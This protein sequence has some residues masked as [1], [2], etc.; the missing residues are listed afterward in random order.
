[1][2][3]YNSRYTG[4]QIDTALASALEVK[5][6]RGLI[7]MTDDGP[8]AAVPGQDFPNS[9][10]STVSVAGLLK[11]VRNVE[12]GEIEVQQAQAGVDFQAPLIPGADYAIPAAVVNKQNKIIATGLLKGIGDGSVVAAIPGTDFTTPTK[13]RDAILYAA[14]WLGTEPPFTQTVTVDGVLADTTK[15]AIHVSPAGG[16]GAAYGAAGIECTVQATNALT[17]TCTAVP[18]SDI[19]VNIS[20]QEA[21]I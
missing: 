17:F 19:T 8:V 6:V 1:M 14:S 18:D 9:S 15:Q 12:T 20:I 21:A 4:A 11:G 5:Q 16:Q 3:E 7:K 13:L 10:G 2:S